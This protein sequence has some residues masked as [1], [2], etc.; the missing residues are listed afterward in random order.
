MSLLH[1][2]SRPTNSSANDD[3]TICTHT[4][5]HT[6]TAGCKNW[7]IFEFKIHSL[8]LVRHKSLCSLLYSEWPGNCHLSADTGTGIRP[9]GMEPRHITRC[10]HYIILNSQAVASYWSSVSGSWPRPQAGCS[11]RREWSLCLQLDTRLLAQHYLLA[12][13]GGE[14]KF[15]TKV[16]LC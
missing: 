5:T 8:L 6:H 12:G 4:H 10:H 11:V 2:R 14:S 15:N 7:V 16:C 13:I 3:L 9:P 1:I